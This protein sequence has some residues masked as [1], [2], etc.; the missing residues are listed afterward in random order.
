MLK[1]FIGSP[2]PP[3]GPPPYLA[4]L[5]KKIPPKKMSGKARA[6]KIPKI[7]APA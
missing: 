1:G 3:P 7:A 5:I 6:F 4:L 2:P